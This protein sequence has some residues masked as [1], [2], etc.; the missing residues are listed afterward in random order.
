MEWSA[1]DSVIRNKSTADKKTLS[2]EGITLQQ[3]QCLDEEQYNKL[4]KCQYKQS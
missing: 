2:V 3:T 4:I 1:Q